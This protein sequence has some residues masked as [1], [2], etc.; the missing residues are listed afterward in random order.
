MNRLNYKYLTQ[1]IQCEAPSFEQIH[2]FIDNNNNDSDYDRDNGDVVQCSCSVCLSEF[3]LS[4]AWVGL[5][6][7]GGIPAA[8]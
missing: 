4:E 8:Q 2:F 1:L 5:S 3:L 6:F 7:C